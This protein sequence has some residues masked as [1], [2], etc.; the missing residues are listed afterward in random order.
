MPVQILQ[1]KGLLTA[2]FA[3]LLVGCS[4]GTRIAEIVSKEPHAALPSGVRMVVGFQPK[5]IASNPLVARLRQAMGQDQ[6]DLPLADFAWAAG[7]DS[8]RQVEAGAWG[9]YSVGGPAGPTWGIVLVGDFDEPGALTSAKAGAGGLAPAAIQPRSYQKGAYYVLTRGAGPEAEETF[10]LFPAPGVALASNNQAVVQKGIV[11][12]NGKAEGVKA[13]PQFASR[14]E[15]LSTSSP[16]WIVGWAQGTLDQMTAIAGLFSRG[17]NLGRGVDWYRAELELGQNMA[18]LSGLIQCQNADSAKKQRENYQELI[19]TYAQVFFQA[20]L[21]IG[22][23]ALANKLR[24]AAEEKTISVNFEVTAEE[25]EQI[26]QQFEQAR[27]NPLTIQDLMRRGA[28]APPGVEPSEPGAEAQEA[29]QE[30]APP[31]ALDEALP[32]PRPAPGS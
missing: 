1:R 13:D 27:Q 29:P 17:E 11:V 24:L 21:G 22:A 30:E 20:G 16:A 19:K 31:G 7:I 3:V 4:G 14:L 23:I 8:Q 2:G 32:S 15:G 28:P 18:S 9:L 26:A 25:I 10:V 6:S 5:N 12:W